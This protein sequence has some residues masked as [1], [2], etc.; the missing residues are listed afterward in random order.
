MILF[1][2]RSYSY[3]RVLANFSFYYGCYV[4]ASTQSVGDSRV[5]Y[6]CVVEVQLTMDIRC[7]D[8]RISRYACG[9]FV[10][11]LVVVIVMHSA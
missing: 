11:D 9:V 7:S 1:L 6:T 8:R 4:R 5:R 10:R 3:S 2:L